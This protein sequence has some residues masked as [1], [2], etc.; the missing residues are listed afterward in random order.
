MITRQ[1]VI[2]LSEKVGLLVYDDFYPYSVPAHQRLISRLEKFA[3]E[4]YD[5][6]SEDGYKEAIEKER[7]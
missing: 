6:G 5:Q 7:G 3:E 1:E 2:T 4:C